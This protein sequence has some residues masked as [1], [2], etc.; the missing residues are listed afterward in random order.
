MTASSLTF[1]LDVDGVMTDGTFWYDHTGK[2]LKRFGPE[3]ADALQ[4]MRA[5]LQ[6][7]FVSADKRG[8]PISEAR[9]ARDMGFDLELVASEDRYA[10]L[11][12]E[13]GLDSTIYMGDSF[14][15]AVIIRDC[16]LGIAPANA[17]PVARQIADHV[18]VSRGG[19]GA[20][21]EACFFLNTFL[22]LQVPEFELGNLGEIR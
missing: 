22:G 15:D 12:Q 13:I 5:F 17:S 7:R 1:C 9:I 4:I 21:A 3:D 19:Q 11:E 2:L 10:W 20:V 8:F 6:I 14:K 16:M 18:T